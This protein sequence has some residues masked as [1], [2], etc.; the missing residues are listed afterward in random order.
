MILGLL[1]K[2]MFLDPLSSVAR[3]DGH[4]DQPDGIAVFIRFGSGHA[5]DGRDQMAG[6]RARP[7]MAM[8]KATS[9]LTA[10]CLASRSMG[11]STAAILFS[12]V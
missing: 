11:T 6:Q 10:V 8:A 4:K 9:A 5:G 3:R 7:P 1:T 12:L 2:L